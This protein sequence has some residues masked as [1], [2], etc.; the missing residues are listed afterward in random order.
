[1]NSFYSDTPKK[2][3]FLAVYDDCS[4]AHVFIL[5]DDGHYICPFEDEHQERIV[6]NN[7]EWFID[8]GFVW[9]FELDDSF[10]TLMEEK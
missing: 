9:F 7:V 6:I 2:G 5:N 3:A 8:A 10:I 1:M 4:G